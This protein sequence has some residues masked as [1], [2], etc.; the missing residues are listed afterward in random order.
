M[1]TVIQTPT[2]NLEESRAFYDALGFI[3]FSVQ[4]NEVLSDGKGL[5]EINPDRFARAGIKLY[6]D[7]WGKALI[8]ELEN[9]TTVTT[10]KHGYALCD[11]SGT[12]LYLINA[13]HDYDL[14]LATVSPSVLGNNAGISIETP[15]MKISSQIWR[16]VGFTNQQGTPE[17]GWVSLTNED[18]ITVSLMK[19][20]TCPHLFFN[21]SLTFFNGE[22]NLEIIKKVRSLKIPITEEITHFNKEGKVDNI[23]IRDPGGLGFFLFND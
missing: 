19:P 14:N 13:K 8:D 7:G 20:N 15:N 9:L 18:N 1:K 10:T 17:Q 11:P 22:N 3:N 5:I 6:Q 2:P 16:L 23:I 4:P 12:W 21:P